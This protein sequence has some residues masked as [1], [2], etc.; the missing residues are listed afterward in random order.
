MGAVVQGSRVW[1]ATFT[2][3]VIA[4]RLVLVPLLCIL[5][6]P[7]PTGPGAAPGLCC[8]VTWAYSEELLISGLTEGLSQGALLPC[9]FGSWA[10][11][12]LA[13]LTSTLQGSS[14]RA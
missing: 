7:F 9:S 8:C 5:H 6:H 3:G 11:A 14:K 13:G 4:S 10:G 2:K 12:G 1:G